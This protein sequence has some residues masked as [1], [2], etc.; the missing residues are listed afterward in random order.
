MWKKSR[1]LW[2]NFKDQIR[3]LFSLP[4]ALA[5]GAVQRGQG[6]GGGGGAQIIGVEIRDGWKIAILRGNRRGVHWPSQDGSRQRPQPNLQFRILNRPSCRIRS[7]MA[8]Q[9]DHMLQD[10]SVGIS[11]GISGRLSVAPVFTN[12][13][14]SLLLPG[15]FN[16]RR[17]F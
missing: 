4:Y 6:G 14:D 11:A 12:R 10:N 7:A 3:G 5:T 17:L 13:A 2:C 8:H 9:S 1:R 16:A 15:G